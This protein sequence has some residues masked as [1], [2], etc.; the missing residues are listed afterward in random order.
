MGKLSNS[1]YKKME[2]EISNDGNKK[3][4]VLW[5][6]ASI[7]YSEG[8]LIIAYDGTEYQRF[9]N[10]PYEHL[11]TRQTLGNVTEKQIRGEWTIVGG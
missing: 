4:T 10:R 3:I 2:W 5:G 6:Q 1:D 8:K 11:N 9:N 7:A